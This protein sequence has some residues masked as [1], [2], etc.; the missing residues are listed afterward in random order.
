MVHQYADK[1]LLLDSKLAAGHAVKGSA[2]LL[3]DWK[4]KE[5]F[6]ALQKAIQLNPGTT[7]AHQMLAY[8]YMITG[9][10]NNAVD[11]MEQAYQVDPLSPIVNK[12]LVDAYNNAERADDALKQTERMLEIY[13]HMLVAHELKGWSIGMAGDWKKAAEIFEENHR[14]FVK[15]P[16]KGLFSM[17]C[18]YGHA[19]E[20]D[21]TLECIRKTE[22]RQAEEPA[23]VLDADLAMMWLSLGEL[24]KGFHYLFQCVDKRMGPVAM[25]MNHP[26]FKMPT[27]DVRYQLLKEKLKLIEFS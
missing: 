24:D 4:W 8:Y 1:A 13:P 5:A 7:D 3:Y 25:I 18:A 22:Q 2:Y 23:M 6:D 16:L 12:T 14:T 17:G 19:G 11:I 9:Q 27:D 15:D 10:R 26:M 21:K 20:V